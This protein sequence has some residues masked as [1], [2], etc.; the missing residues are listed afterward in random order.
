MASQDLPT[1]GH[2]RRRRPSVLQWKANSLRR[3]QANLSLH[4]LRSEYDVLALQEVYAAAAGLRLPG[5]VGHSSR[6]SYT[7]ESC[8]SAPCLDEGYHQGAPQCAVYVRR[9]LLQAEVH[10][11]DLLSGPVECCA[12]RVRLGGYDT[13]VASIYVRPG[14]PWNTASLLPLARRLGNDF[15][16][17]GDVN[18]HHTAWGS[19]CCCPRGQ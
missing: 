16:L 17:C 15:V 1:E 2:C 8:Q 14:R 6:T 9:E 18:A 11:A 7:S 3:R 5:Y 4:L 12:V 13:T 19:R 10:V